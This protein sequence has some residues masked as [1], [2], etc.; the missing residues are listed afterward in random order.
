MSSGKSQAGPEKGTL[1]PLTWPVA[2]SW[3]LTSRAGPEPRPSLGAQGRL[4][5]GPR[6]ESRPQESSGQ[7]PA[8]S[9]GPLG[10]PCSSAL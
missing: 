3:P 10:F 9:P 4:A 5:P 8:W 2:S 6:S 7:G 1:C